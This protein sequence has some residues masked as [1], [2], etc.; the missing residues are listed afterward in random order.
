MSSLFER[1]YKNKQSEQGRN[2]KENFLT[3]I[4]AYCLR[5]DLNFRNKFLKFIGCIEDC[6]DF[7]CVTQFSHNEFGRPDILI[8][9]D[10]HTMIIIECKV[11]STQSETQLNRYAK[12]L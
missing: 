10:N 12:F 5:S 3:E 2:Q 4:F 8:K 6:K 7:D 1:L 9:I 11:D